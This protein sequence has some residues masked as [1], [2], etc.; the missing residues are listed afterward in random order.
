MSPVPRSACDGMHDLYFRFVRATT[1]TNTS[2]GD[3]F[4]FAGV[5]YDSTT[6]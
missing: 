5:Q 4:K 2:N 3:R 1:E 6:N